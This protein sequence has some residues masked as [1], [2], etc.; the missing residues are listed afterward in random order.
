MANDNHYEL[1]LL[2]GLSFEE[3]PIEYKITNNPDKNNNKAY[4]NKYDISN[5]CT[6]IN[7]KKNNLLNNDISDDF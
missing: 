2:I 5:S 6:E 4:T 7:N 1:L 3:Y